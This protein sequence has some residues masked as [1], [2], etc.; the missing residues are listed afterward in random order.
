MR[1][2]RRLVDAVAGSRGWVVRRVGLERVV[3]VPVALGP[4]EHGVDGVPLGSGLR[5]D[6]EAAA[7]EVNIRPVRVEARDEEARARFADSDRDVPQFA[8][9][10]PFHRAECVSG[11]VLAVKG[12]GPV[13]AIPLPADRLPEL[14]DAK[15]LRAELGVSR[16][17]AEAIM[18]QVLI[19]AVEGLR[20]T[21]V[22]RS[23]VAA[24]LE[25]R[26]FAKTEVPA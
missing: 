19:V 26:T 5:V 23:D 1:R 18:R 4:V 10:F 16:D 15:A 25:A 6:R 8:A 3:Q 14:L 9:S 20:K 13:S 21:Y 24:Y 7:R 2:E 11:P 12:N 17:A 22:R